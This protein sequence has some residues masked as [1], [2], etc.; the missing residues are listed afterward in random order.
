M[1][2]QRKELMQRDPLPPPPTKRRDLVISG[3]DPLQM[4]TPEKMKH[5]EIGFPMPTVSSGID[6]PDPV[7][8]SPENVATP[9]VT[10]QPSRQLVGPG[11]LP[12]PSTDGLD[13]RRIMQ[14]PLV[15]SG[16]QVGKHP[17]LDIPLRP[18]RRGNVP[19]GRKP[20]PRV[21][22][23]T[24]RRHPKTISPGPMQGGQL[25]PKPLSRTPRRLPNRHGLDDK[26]L[27]V[28]PEHSG[29]LWTTA[30]AHPRTVGPL[31][32]R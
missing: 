1:H 17:M 9:E 24:G 3:N 6:E 18:G 30:R 8:G 25:P 13:G 27:V 19:H 4:R 26:P 21:N 7:L 14:N 16:P 11:K 2:K 12:D 29:N 32:Q 28:K 31:S 20:N 15:N 23:P 5:R 10:M 22:R